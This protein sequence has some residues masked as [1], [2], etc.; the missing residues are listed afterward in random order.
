MTT[1]TDPVVNAVKSIEKEEGGA[2][3]AKTHAKILT[4]EEW[5]EIEPPFYYI[6]ITFTQWSDLEWEIVHKWVARNCTDWAYIDRP[7]LV[8]GSEDDFVLFRMWAEDKPMHD[9][10]MLEVK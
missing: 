2:G 8:F 10:D 3:E 5:L 7:K 9:A 4:K 1:L 6:R